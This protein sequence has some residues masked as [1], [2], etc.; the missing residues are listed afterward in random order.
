MKAHDHHACIRSGHDRD[1]A[2]VDRGA[3][4]AFDHGHFLGSP[5]LTSV[6]LSQIAA[7]FDNQ[8]SVPALANSLVWLGSGAGGILMSPLAERI[9]ARATV[10]FGGLM[11]AAGFGV[12]TLGGPTMLLVG[13]GLL[14]GILGTG[15][16]HAPLY[17]YISRWFD[18][19]R[20]TA[21]ALVASG[22]YVGSAFWPPLLLIV[23]TEWGWQSAM[24]F[25]GAVALLVITP[26][27]ALLLKPE[28]AAPP[29]DVSFEMDASRSSRP[30]ALFPLLCIASVLCCIP[31]AIPTAHLPALCGDF[32]IAPS[33]GAGMLS[34]LLGI[35][36]VS[37]Q[38]WGWLSDR[39]GG[40][41]TV[42]AAS[43]C[44]AIAIG[45]FLVARSEAGLFTVSAGFG[46]GFS[47]IIPAYILSVR[48]LFPESDAKWRVPAV[49][50]CSRIGMAG[51]LDR[52]RDL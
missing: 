19:H 2:V 42:A 43:A 25:F 16:I 47:G 48:Q 31:M 20:G 35:G 7:S 23:L 3:R 21:L 9:G 41:A 8:R 51:W 6:G 4:S 28:P 33:T 29:S 1:Q 13:H 17:V 49:F 50:F 46:L 26:I 39:I 30:V 38:V 45:G 14:I 11:I 34:L 52:G 10:I 40:L 36:F 22:Q 24:I 18:R 15:A 44:Q 32:G 37:R 12:S 5:L 27:A